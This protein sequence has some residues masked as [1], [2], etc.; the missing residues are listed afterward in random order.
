MLGV[1]IVLLGLKIYKYV[2]REWHI[3]AKNYHHLDPS[4]FLSQ[5]LC[6]HK[7]T[8]N[9]SVDLDIEILGYLNNFWALYLLDAFRCV[10]V[11]RVDKF[12]FHNYCKY[13]IKLS[14]FTGM[15]HECILRLQLAIWQPFYLL[16]FHTT[17]VMR[18]ITTFRSKTDCIDDGGFIIL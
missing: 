2:L 3:E 13:N 8:E 4:S 12:Q 11:I 15:N 1:I 10:C 14:L 7:I 16:H 5:F 17:S 18:R 9:K 6:L